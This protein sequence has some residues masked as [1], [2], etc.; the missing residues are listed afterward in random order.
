MK[1]DKKELNIIIALIGTALVIAI[2]VGFKMIA[3]SIDN[4]IFG[5]SF[6]SPETITTIDINTK[7][8]LT[9]YEA[10]QYLGISWEALI[11]NVENGNYKGNYIKEVSII[12]DFFSYVFPREELKDWFNDY[13]KTNKIIEIDSS[14]LPSKDR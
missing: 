11:S 13:M 12:N 2:I 3:N 6:S 9:D 8:F 5:S 14:N 1:S 7:D 4:N 10:S